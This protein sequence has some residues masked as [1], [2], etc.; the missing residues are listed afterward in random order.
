VKKTKKAITAKTIAIVGVAGSTSLG[1]VDPID[2]LSSIALEKGIYLHVDAAIGGY[3]LPFLK[4]LGYKAPLFDFKLQG[5]SSMT[6]DPHKMGMSVIPAG[7]LIYRTKAIAETIKIF[8][9]YLSGGE[10]AR[11]TIA[12]TSS[13]ASVLAVWALLKH[14]GRNGYRSIVRRCMDLTY[15]LAEQ[16]QSTD[17]FR[18]VCEPTINIVGISSKKAP[19]SNVAAFLR[20]RGWAISVFPE[21]I[22][23]VCMPHVYTEHIHR[24]VDDLKESARLSK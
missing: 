13:G 16:V 22:R 23:I 21:H 1:V 24:F 3:V 6:I 11:A 5:I 15:S 14:L 12:G 2:E 9:P 4:E 8:V 18:I 17:G 20:K 19:I 7:G 10:S